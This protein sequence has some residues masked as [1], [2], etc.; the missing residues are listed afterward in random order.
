[1]KC[2]NPSQWRNIE[3][4]IS[5]FFFA[6]LPRPGSVDG[7][8]S[9]TEANARQRSGV[10]P[11]ERG[12]LGYNDPRIRSSK[13]CGRSAQPDCKP[14]PNVNSVNFRDPSCCVSYFRR[15]DCDVQRS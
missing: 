1:M 12:V 3:V 14:T 11:P 2:I 10:H 15:S 9:R 7:M 4:L 6:K 13:G 5:S 8:R